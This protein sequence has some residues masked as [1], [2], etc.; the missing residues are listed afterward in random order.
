[1]N[2]LVSLKYCFISLNPSCPFT[3]RYCYTESKVK[4]TSPPNVYIYNILNI[5]PFTF[6]ME[7]V[8]RCR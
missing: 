6:H 3:K 4:I 1:M 7:D 2:H 5:K 8:Y